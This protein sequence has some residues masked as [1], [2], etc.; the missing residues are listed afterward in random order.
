LSTS[1]DNLYVNIKKLK[2]RPHEPQQQQNKSLSSKETDS[3]HGSGKRDKSSLVS[4]PATTGSSSAGLLLTTSSSAMSS[5]SRPS[6]KST[7]RALNQSK[8]KDEC[9]SSVRCEEPLGASTDNEPRLARKRPLK[10]RHK[11]KSQTEAA[12]EQAGFFNALFRRFLTILIFFITP[13]LMVLSGSY[14]YTYYLSPG[15]CDHQ[16]SYL[17]FNVT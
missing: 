16:R 4:T 6:K 2:K 10:S 12:A 11:A 14:V 8:P 7:K 1:P 15:C 5:P 3:G 13:L 17:I 9:V